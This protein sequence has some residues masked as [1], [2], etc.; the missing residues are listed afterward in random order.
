MNQ[1]ARELTVYGAFLRGHN[2]HMVFYECV[3]DIVASG[4]SIEDVKDLLT[5]ARL[6]EHARIS[7]VEAAPYEL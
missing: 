6:A 3:K 1:E 7:C 5:R 4:G 2:K